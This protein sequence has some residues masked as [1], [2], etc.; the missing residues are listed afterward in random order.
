MLPWFQARGPF[1]PVDQLRASYVAVST[2]P[3]E[4]ASA[5]LAALGTTLDACVRDHAQMFWAL[6]GLCPNANG[7]LTAQVAYLANALAS[8]GRLDT[9]D[10]LKRARFIIGV[11]AIVPVWCPCE[12]EAR[13]DN[14]SER[15]RACA[16]AHAHDSCRRRLTVTT[17]SAGSRNARTKARVLG[18][19]ETTSLISCLALPNP[20]SWWPADARDQELPRF[21]EMCRNS[22]V[23]SELV[24]DA[25]RAIEAE[26]SIALYC[27]S[28]RHRSLAVALAVLECRQPD[29]P[30]ATL[31]RL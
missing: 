20:Q 9:L 31:V 15:A 4:R 24:Y 2:L 28:G 27:R 16:W 3:W 10:E 25:R 18:I 29:D 1:G 23:F 6:I 22:D 17:F 5:Q 11:D 8:A 12:L 7:A 21:F 13:P 19:A 30:I 26:G 14:F